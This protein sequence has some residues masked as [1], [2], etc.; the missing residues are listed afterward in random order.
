[1]QFQHVHNELTDK[2]EIAIIKKYDYIAK[3]Y[4][5]TL[6]IFGICAIFA[7]MAFQFWINMINFA[8]PANVSRSYNFLIMMEYFIDQDTYFYL[9]ILHTTLATCI[10]TISGVACS[11]LF[12]TFVQHSCG[13]LKIASYR[14]EHAINMNIKRNVMPE[15]EILMTKGISYAVD[16]HRQAL[17]L[18]KHLL[19]IVE[20]MLLSFLLFLV[21]CLSLN[22][23]RLMICKNIKYIVVPLGCVGVC[24][25]YMFFFNLLGQIVT[26]HNNDVFITTYNVYW[27]R[28]PCHIQRMILFLLQKGIKEF[29][30]NI[31]GIFDISIEGFTTLVKTSVSYFTVISSIQ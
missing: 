29:H 20:T 11:T 3:C 23:F 21:L 6:M 9:I 17:K 4:T 28:T 15:N 2:T 1:M 14:I 25:I 24:T 16:I 27:Y 7:F 22:L 30:F 31:G 8:L 12:L 19:S 26:D 18:N 13:M 5:V 10:G